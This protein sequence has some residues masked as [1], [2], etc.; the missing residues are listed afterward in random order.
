MVRGCSQALESDKRFL[1]EKQRELGGKLQKAKDSSASQKQELERQIR[2][3]KSE[4]NE[5]RELV[6]DKQEAMDD[7]DRQHRRKNDEYESRHRALVQTSNELREEVENKNR[8][9]EKIQAKLESKDREVQ[10]LE[11]ELLNVKAHAGDQEIAKILKKELGEQVNHIKTLESTG[12]KQLAELKTLRETNRSL[13]LVDEEKRA[14]EGKL[15]ML[16]ELRE[17]LS[18]S[19]LRVSVLEDERN[20]W[21]SYFQRE[22]LEFD[23]P[24]SLARALVEER[25]EKVALLEKAGRL[26]PELLEKEGIIRELEGELRLLK[27]ELEKSRESSVKDSKARQRMERQRALALKEAQFLREQLKSISTEESMYNQGSYDEQKAARIQELEALLEAYKT[28]VEGLKAAASSAEVATSKKR[29]CEENSSDERLGEL[30]RRNRQLQ[31]G[32]R[33]PSIRGLN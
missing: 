10:G 18:V 4:N 17:E 29:A 16:D 6:N 19:Q 2:R 25:V 12:R 28:E 1:F 21:R 15:K 23:S 30:I 3:L 20:T 5:F 32:S 33:C 22:G 11:V 9:M 26:N 27:E 31:N 8:A 7:Q 14:L 13:E 24:E